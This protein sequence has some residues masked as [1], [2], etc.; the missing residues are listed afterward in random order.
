M[1]EEIVDLR[2]CELSDPIQANNK[3][4]YQEHKGLGW[5]ADA[6]AQREPQEKDEL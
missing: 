6:C 5:K 2:L 1:P 4:F 3:G